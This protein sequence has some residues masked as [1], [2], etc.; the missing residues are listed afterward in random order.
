MSEQTPLRRAARLCAAAAAALL[1]CLAAAWLCPARADLDRIRSYTVTVDPRA[2]GSADITYDIDW[3]VIGGSADEPLSWVRIG[4]A[5]GEADGFENLSPDTVSDVRYMDGD[6]GSFARVT[7]KKRYYPPDYAAASGQE[8]RVR[9]AFRVHQSHLYTRDE[10]GGAVYV[11]TPGWFSDLSIDQMTVRWYAGA[12]TTAD[13]DLLQDGY[14]VWEFGALGHDERATV[15]VTVSPE[16]AAGFAAG[17]VMPESAPAGT[18]TAQRVFKWLAVVVLLAAA[19]FA[20][21]ALLSLRPRWRGGFGA[22]V[23]DWV[24]Y[25]NGVHTIHLAPGRAPPAGY[26]RT[27]PPPGFKAGGGRFRGGGAGKSD[28]NDHH[29][30]GC[31]CACACV[32]CACACAC[33]GGGRAGCSVK[34]FYR[35]RLH[36]GANGGQQH[37]H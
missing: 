23:P 14:Y 19:L 16:A 2:D 32:S 17:T 33:A 7:F 36:G 13:T 20:L 31:A 29:S 35:I 9:F 26:T 10:N 21:A 4:L 37:E 5:N 24:F 15:R 11:F 25:T 3:E 12:G 8:S 34:N 22:A 1:L 6:G 27:A 18:G 30:A 28:S